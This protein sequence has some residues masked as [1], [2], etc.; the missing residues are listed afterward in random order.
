MRRYW[1]RIA[2]GALLIFCVGYG[3]VSAGRYFKNTVASGKDLTI[4]FGSLV[5]FK[6]DGE[7]VGTLRSL[8]IHRTAPK[9]I[10]GFGLRVRLSDSAAFEKLQ[11]CKLTVS[12]PMRIDEH[13]TFSCVS[14]EAGY[15]PFGNVSIELRSG[16]D[17]RTV[18]ETLLLTDATVREIRSHAADSAAG[19]SADSIAAAIRDRVRSQAKAIGDSIR[20]VELDRVADRM[21]EKAEAIRARSGRTPADTTGRVKPPPP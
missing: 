20:A 12:D 5:P 19:P 18:V 9:E 2:L 4:P 14:E 3:F 1:T 11:G 13:T 10:V 16:H 21:K 7:K 8:V 17:S 6:L 15:Q